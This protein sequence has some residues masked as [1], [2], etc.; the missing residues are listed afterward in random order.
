[1][2]GLKMMFDRGA[3]KEAVLLLTLLLLASWL[4]V[5]S[6]LDHQ[7]HQARISEV[8]ELLHSTDSLVAS[9]LF[10]ESRGEADFDR[11]EQATKN[12]QAF[13][14]QQKISPSG[15]QA[16]ASELTRLLSTSVKLQANYTAYLKM[17]SLFFDN[18]RVLRDELLRSH[19]IEIIFEQNDL[20]WDIIRYVS[21]NQGDAV[22]I[23]GRLELFVE[24]VLNNHSRAKNDAVAFN[25]YSL[26]LL[27]YVEKAKRLNEAMFSDHVQRLSRQAIAQYEKDFAQALSNAKHAK[28]AFYIGTFVLLCLSFILRIKQRGAIKQLS[29]N[30]KTLGFSL[31]MA[32]Q[33][34]FSVDVPSEEV[35]LGQEYSKALGFGSKEYKMSMA[36]WRESVHPD[37]R[38]VTVN[39]LDASMKSGEVFE[40]EY[41]WKSRSDRWLWLRTIARVVQRDKQGS[42]LKMAGISSN[43]NER[44]RNEQVLRV[45]AECHSGGGAS[46]TIFHSIVRELGLAKGVRLAIIAKV[47]AGEAKFVETLAVWQDG[48]FAKNFSYALEGTPCEKI[49]ER[50]AC[51]YPSGVQQLFPD[52]EHLSM[53]ELESYLGVPLVNSHDEVIGLL[54]ILGDKPMTDQALTEPLMLSLATRAA[55]EI[56]R[57]Q[58]DQKLMQL[59]HYDAL[60]GLPNRSLLSDRFLQAQAHNERTKGLLAVCFLDLDNFK[61]INDVYGHD[62]GDQLLQQVSQRLLGSIR[63][64]D[65]VS[66]LGGDEFVLLLSEITDAKECEQSLQRVLSL[67]AKPYEI[68]GESL[69]ISA[70]VGY[71]LSRSPDD[72]LDVLIRQADHAMYSAKSKGKNNYSLFDVGLDQRRSK[73]QRALRSLKRAY[74]EGEFC[75]YYQPKINM[76]TG[77]VY[78]MEALIRWKDPKRGL[79]PPLEFLPILDA[80]ELE[81]MVGDWVISEAL[82]QMS[83]WTA[84]GVELEVSVNISSYHLLSGDFTANLAKA[85]SEQPM[86][87][88]NLLQLEV[89]ESSILGDIGSVRQVLGVC[90]DAL[91]V[92]I[93]LD[94]FGTGYSSLAH[95]R[96]LP[97]G[98]V[99]IDRSFIRDVLHNA[100]DFAIVKAVIGL[101]ESFNLEVIAEGVESIEQGLALLE[102]GCDCAQGYAI[103]RPMPAVD[104]LAWLESYQANEAWCA[105]AS[106]PL[107]SMTV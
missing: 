98:T 94:D 5:V 28:L 74:L 92:K 11:V 1:M 75:L 84:Q 46:K 91:G 8:N 9:T 82:R 93:A 24:S 54:S 67:L 102:M 40:Q 97:A 106:K 18:T 17:R 99:K 10:I 104:V 64:D 100:N 95:L 43:I 33:G 87:A 76:G 14:T 44:K 65:T 51:F 25:R 90:R 62:A 7:A 30:T 27:H 47:E 41:R 52:D 23:G 21:L 20:Q 26:A 81:I 2:V 29:S 53:M 49:V 71:T 85:L 107:T 77:V 56:E 72:E 78:G 69:S 4:Y 83:L 58:A 35:L 34:Q 105:Y 101:T 39:A 103:S 22:S 50:T 42:P 66:R 59:A 15:F 13:L 68:D 89:L 36:E 19:A 48:D 16:L 38:S 6:D 12:L 37:D 96:S 60:T 80:T 32:K 45:I 70:S 31:I 55:M 88:P 61:P 3:V 63:G 86:V 79:I 73:K 57:Q